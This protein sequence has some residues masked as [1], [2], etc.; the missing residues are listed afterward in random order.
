MAIKEIDYELEGG[1]A[2]EPFICT[3]CKRECGIGTDYLEVH[4]MDR[5]WGP[6]CL[7]C[8]HKVPMMFETVAEHPGV[9]I[10]V[11]AIREQV[12]SRYQAAKCREN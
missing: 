7:E 8:W 11:E 6:L 10:D 4:V 1:Q 5:I 2:D 9:S 12:M 3:G